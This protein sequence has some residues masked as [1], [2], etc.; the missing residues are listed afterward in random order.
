[1]ASAANEAKV[2][3]A[4]KPKGKAAKNWQMFVAKALK[5]NVTTKTGPAAG[6]PAVIWEL[7]GC[8]ERFQMGV[9]NVFSGEKDVEVC[10]RVHTPA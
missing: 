3:P 10:A 4:A 6:K 9:L 1:M 7:T 2:A 8:N 5:K